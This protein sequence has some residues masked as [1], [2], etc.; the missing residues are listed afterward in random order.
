MGQALRTQLF[1]V[2]AADPWTLAAAT[3]LVIG[4]AV[5]ASVIPAVRAAGVDPVVALRQE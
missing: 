4:V 3:A 5:A 1:R 2:H